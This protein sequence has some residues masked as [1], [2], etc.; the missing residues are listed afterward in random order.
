MNNGDFIGAIDIVGGC[1]SAP[2]VF[3]FN[4][5][6]NTLNVSPD[7]II[8]PGDSAYINANASPANIVWQ[9]NGLGFDTTSHSV[10]VAP[11]N[12]MY[13]VAVHNSGACVYSDSVL[14]TVD[15][16]NNCTPLPSDL[17]SNA[18]SPNGDGVNDLWII[19][20][21]I[22]YPQNVVSVFN[23]WGDKILEFNN[24]DNNNVVWDGKSS[25]GSELPTGTYFYVIEYT[26]IDQVF[27]GWIQITK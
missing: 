8:C 5:D 15:A 19:D 1:S 17:T 11:T 12:T 4:I 9:S 13:F 25:D 21:V 26:D 10:W 24:Y 16:N 22:N 14:I 27:N 7:E 3:T 6:I 2:A 20:D 18:F 23:R